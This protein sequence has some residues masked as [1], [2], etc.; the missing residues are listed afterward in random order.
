MAR[1][2]GPYDMRPPAST[3]MRNGYMPGMRCSAANATMRP[4]SGSMTV[5]LGNHEE[6]LD[7]FVA[8]RRERLREPVFVAHLQRVELEAKLRRTVAKA[9]HECD[10]SRHRRIGDDRHPRNTRERFLEQGEL[11]SP[12]LAGAEGP[13]RSRCRPGDSSWRPGPVPLRYGLTITTGVVEVACVAA[14]VADGPRATITS[15]FMAA[16]SRAALARPSWPSP[17]LP[18]S[19]MF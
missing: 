7:P 10:L 16:S 8:H 6:C 2:L 19:S 13:V 14:R 12:G 4:R 15:R 17:V 11:L 9:S 18:C 5:G 1:R 3:Y